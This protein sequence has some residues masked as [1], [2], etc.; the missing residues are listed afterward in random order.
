MMN[1]ERGL[2]KTVLCDLTVLSLIDAII[3]FYPFSVA[4]NYRMIGKW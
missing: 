2:L 3:Y 4:L 1:K